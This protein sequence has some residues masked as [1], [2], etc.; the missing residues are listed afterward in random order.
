M[1][2]R[3]VIYFHRTHPEIYVRDFSGF[4]SLGSYL[5]WFESL[6]EKVPRGSVGF[7]FWKKYHFF[8]KT[9]SRTITFS[10]SINSF[11]A[12][13]TALQH[14]PLR[15]L[16]TGA[17]FCSPRSFPQ[18]ICPVFSPECGS[19]GSM[20]AWWGSALQLGPVAQSPEESEALSALVCV[21]GRLL[22]CC[23][24]YFGTA[25][26]GPSFLVWFAELSVSP[27]PSLSHTITGGIQLIPPVEADFYYAFIIFMIVRLGVLF[28]FF[29][30]KNNIFFGHRNTCISPFLF[31]LSF[32]PFLIP[33]ETRGILL[34]KFTRPVNC[35][36]IDVKPSSFSS[37]VPPSFFMGTVGMCKGVQFGALA[38]A[39]FFCDTWNS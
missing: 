36:K 38:Q 37:R 34:E 33:H 32:P 24:M 7:D 9:I 21:C 15:H 31:P 26:F 39:P 18:H 35:V 17:W 13:T 10:I 28:V 4:C 6:P 5:F 22:L 1:S 27:S 2:E 25:L 19:V 8:S 23:V 20:W 3:H 30:Q 12:F 14:H 16:V 11:V 29:N